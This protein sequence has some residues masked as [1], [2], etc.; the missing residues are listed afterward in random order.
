MC[1]IAGYINIDN[2][3]KKINIKEVLQD[4]KVRGPDPNSIWYSEDY[5]AG[6]CPS[7]LSIVDL[8]SRANQPMISEFI[9]ERLSW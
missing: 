9:Y 3:H 4:I 8:S 2:S 5:T 1:G 7:R 6:F